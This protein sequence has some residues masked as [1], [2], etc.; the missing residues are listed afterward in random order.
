[1]KGVGFLKQSISDKMRG[2]CIFFSVP[3]HLNGENLDMFVTKRYD[4]YIRSSGWSDSAYFRYP[5]LARRLMERVAPYYR[6]RI[7]KKN[8]LRKMDR[9]IINS[10]C[11]TFIW[12][13]RLYKPG[14]K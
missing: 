9:A 7:L 2:K 10:Y 11:N 13:Y 1:M 12:L 5:M 3:Q 6:R 4:H 8:K 14:R